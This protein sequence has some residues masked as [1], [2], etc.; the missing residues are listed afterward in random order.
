MYGHMEFKN[1]N[2][3]RFG[4]VIGL[5]WTVGEE[6][7]YGED[8][9]KDILRLE[10]CTCLT[11]SCL[12]QCTVDDLIAMSTQKHVTAGG[13]NLEQDYRILISFLEKNYEVKSAWR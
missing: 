8:D 7:L 9:D 2:V 10:N 12:L 4:E 1:S 5:G 3:G 13:G 11:T 6:I